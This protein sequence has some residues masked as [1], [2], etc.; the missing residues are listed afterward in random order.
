MSALEYRSGLTPL[1]VAEILKISKNTV[2]EMVKRGEVN[3]YRVGNKFRFDMED[4]EELK[5]RNRGCKSRNRQ[6]CSYEHSQHKHCGFDEL[7][8]NSF[9]ICGQD[10]VINALC[11][12]LFGKPG[13]GVALN[14]QV[15][16]LTSLYELYYGKAQIA[17]VNLW[18]GETNE[19]NIPYVK[20]FMPGVSA[21]VIHIANRKQGIYTAKGNPKGIKSLEDL[22]RKN[23]SIVNRELGSGTRILLDEHL[24]LLGVNPRDINGYDKEYFSQTALINAIAEGEADMA[25]GTEGVYQNANKVDFI[26]LQNESFDLIMKKED[27][28]KTQF[29][30][31]IKTLQA[32]EFKYEVENIVGYDFSDLGKVIGET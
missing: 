16:S 6:Q 5:N 2:Y 4:I 19:Y 29:Q 7:K 8:N 30:A 3:F 22:K 25:I 10:I 28:N 18:D 11:R 23:I 12:H 31:V 27:M 17:V 15:S 32:E 9:I 1:D 14:S 24:K 26:P 13:V 20:K 21:V